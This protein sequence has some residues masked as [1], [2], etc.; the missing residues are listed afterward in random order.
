MPP[1]NI[2][3]RILIKGLK[4]TGVATAFL[5]AAYF[6]PFLLIAFLL[7]G[8]WDISRNTGLDASVFKQYF[9][10]NGIGTWFASPLNITLDILALPY[11][12]KGTYD[13]A[14]LPTAY[15]T[16]ISGL[17]KSADEGGLVEHLESYMGDSPRAMVFFKWY[18]RDQ[19]APIEMPAF[20][21]KFRFVRTI[22]VSAFRERERTSRHFG[23]FRPSLRM[24]YCLD[25]DVAEDAYIK[26]GKVEN[27]WR[28]KRL[29]IFDD[30]L[31]RQSFNETDALRYCLFVDIL[32]PSY[33]PFV[34]DFGV[35]AIR[36][37]FK[38][39][40]GAF[41]KNWKLVNN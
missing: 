10:R 9:L 27:H 29:F 15:Q 2:V 24:L 30:T 20:H 19:E 13:L 37:F 23:P 26:V 21:E 8:L 40:N 3:K 25:E 38:G 39:I 31:L 36:I 14:D 35:S 28:D 33:L 34:F 41:Y 1:K 32:R 6:I 4:Y 11:W 22:G 16:E 12:N 7:C 5:A 18:G 17:L